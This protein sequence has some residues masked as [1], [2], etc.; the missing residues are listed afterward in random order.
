VNLETVKEQADR[1]NALAERQIGEI[2][3][4]KFLSDEGRK[5]QIA[6]VVR[7]TGDQLEKLRQE[8]LAPGIR[9]RTEMER[10]LWGDPGDNILGWRDAMAR[11]A[12]L[13]DVDEARSTFERA[14]RSGDKQLARSI[15]L[16]ARWSGVT[17]GYADSDP[18]WAEAATAPPEHD[19]SNS[20]ARVKM[21][22]SM[23][24]SPP[25]PEELSATSTAEL[26][27]LASVA[28]G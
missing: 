16:D 24:T 23:I 28:E 7:R 5:A 12:A 2:R 25:M 22:L 20:S 4:E 17:A 1:F 18:A 14:T 26:N 11:T 3:Q 9:D 21:S 19:R 27:R 8:T 10:R 6:A 15:A 13:K